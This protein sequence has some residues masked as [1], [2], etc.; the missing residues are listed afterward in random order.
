MQQFYTRAR[1]QEQ[2]TGKICFNEL[3]KISC[4]TIADDNVT[5]SSYVHWQYN[6]YNYV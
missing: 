2:Q 3:S 6:L 5:C 4:V 1:I